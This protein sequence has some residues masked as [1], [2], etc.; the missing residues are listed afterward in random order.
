MEPLEIIMAPFEV[1]VAPVGT[2][3]PTVDAAPGAGWTLL[4]KGG[5]DNMDESGVTVTHSQTLN[6]KRTLGST[7]N[8]KVVRSAE[9]LTIG[10]TLFDLTAE[11]YANALN[12]ATVTTVAPGTGTIGTKEINLRQG[13]DVSLFALIARG[14]SPEL[15]GANGQ[16]QVPKVYQSDNPKPVFKKDDAAGLLFTFTALE[17]LTQ[18]TEAERFGQLI[19][20]HAAAL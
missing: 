20:Q 5:K 10:F 8:I 12:G 9:E 1:Y 16:Y 2:A 14:P 11:M 15:D 4:G 18:A 7:G 17:D 13:R 6:P 19:Y 3:F